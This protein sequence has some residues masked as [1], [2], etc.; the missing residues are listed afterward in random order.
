MTNEQLAEFIQQGGNDE[1]IPIL[2]NNVKNLVYMLSDKI[3]KAHSEH[4]K[5]YGVE[6]WD[7]RQTSYTA[8]L[9][10]IKGFKPEQEYKFT[11]YLNYPIKTAISRELLKG[12]DVLNNCTSLDV[13]LRQ[14]DNSEDTATLQETIP[15]TASN[16]FIEDIDNESIAGVL[17]A[18][19]GKLKAVQQDV[20]IAR[21][22]ENKTFKDVAEC[23]GVSLE[24]VRQIEH[25]ALRE[26]RKNKTIKQLAS[27]YN[28]HNKWLA[29]SKLE[30]CPE[31]F[32]IIRALQEYNLTRGRR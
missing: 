14:S 17:W 5:R 27:E 26:L 10:A 1:L 22:R 8:F 19:V 15:D 4:F 28:E 24:R 32:E 23:L 29:I 9:N 11:S 3:Y 31:H 18:A 13:P 7:V 25:A 30:F 12:N 2:W 21:Y 16:D 20:I 6:Q